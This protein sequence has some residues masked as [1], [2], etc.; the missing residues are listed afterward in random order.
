MRTF[1]LVL[2]VGCAF[3]GASGAE[4]S[5]LTP[6][7]AAKFEGKDKVV[8]VEFVVKKVIPVIPDGEHVRLF[9]ERSIKDKGVFVVH[10]TDKAVAKMA[11]KDLESHYLGQKIRVTGKWA[12]SF[13]AAP[14]RRARAS[15]STTRRP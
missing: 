2:A 5:F 15:L 11:G 9:S 3:T 10:M 13:S 1:V 12:R 8:T 6:A 14:R 4:E 7:E